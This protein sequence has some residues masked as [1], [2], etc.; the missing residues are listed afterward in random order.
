MIGYYDVGGLVGYN[1]ISAVSNSFWDSHT[2]GQSSSA[3]GTGKTTTE[4]IDV[5]TFTSLLT[6]GLDTAWDFVTDPNDDTGTD[7]FWNMDGLRFNDGYPFLSWQDSEVSPDT[8]TNVL[9][10]IV[11]DDVE[12]SWDDMSATTYHIFRSTDPYIGDWGDAI[13]N[14]DVNSYTDEGAA[15][16]TKYFYYVTATN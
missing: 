7:D 1:S 6:A 4:M 15:S 14:S 13:G 2:S 9:I 3:G 10:T 11:G 16:G 12:L 8:P 5:A